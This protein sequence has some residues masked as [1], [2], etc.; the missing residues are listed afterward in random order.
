MGK[1]AGT[2]N[3]RGAIRTTAAASTVTAPTNHCRLL[4]CI[5]RS[6]PPA[7]L[8]VLRDL[9]SCSSAN[10]DDSQA[11]TGCRTPRRAACDIQ[12]DRD[13]GAVDIPGAGREYPF[14]YVR[15]RIEGPT[16]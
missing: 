11:S 1:K 6:P 9:L 12:S 5:A 10:L 2:P 8:R 13:R 15:A 7:S 16:P 3:R 4:S 14:G